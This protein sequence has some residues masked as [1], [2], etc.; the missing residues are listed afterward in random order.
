MSREAARELAS[1]LIALI[2]RTPGVEKLVLFGHSYGGIVVTFCA[3]LLHLNIPVEINAVAA[4]LAGYPGLLEKCDLD[5][6]EDSTLVYPI[7]DSSLVHIQWKTQHLLDNAFNSL[8]EDPQEVHLP[9]SRHYLL[10]PTMDGHRLGHNWS[11]SW[12]VDE[13]LGIPHQP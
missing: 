7:W 8:P 4:P 3:G 10:P 6:H 9:L 13:Y 2:H 5:I 1:S 12:V 11:V